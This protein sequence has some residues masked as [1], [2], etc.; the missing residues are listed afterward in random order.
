MV[1]CPEYL[2]EFEA[3]RTAIHAGHPPD[4]L[5]PYYDVGL[6]TGHLIDLARQQAA[7]CFPAV[8]ARI[9][10]LLIEGSSQVRNWVGAGLLE[11]M[12]NRLANEGIGYAVPRVIRS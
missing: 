11:A 8:F 12:Q 6:F 9:E 4:A 2:S 10:Q 1:T 3:T 7:T 5:D